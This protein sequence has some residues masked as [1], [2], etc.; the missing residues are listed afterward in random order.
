M[1][2]HGDENMTGSVCIP[3]DSVRRPARGPSANVQSGFSLL[4]VLASLVIMGII[5]ASV[6]VSLR[7]GQTALNTGAARWSSVRS[8]ERLLQSLRK[9]CNA[10]GLGC[11]VSIA[12][13]SLVASDGT[14]IRYAFRKG[15]VERRS[16]NDRPRTINI[17]GLESAGLRLIPSYRSDRQVLVCSLRYDA[18]IREREK[19]YWFLLRTSRP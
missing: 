8:E 9:D 13:L 18:K 19:E 3:A 4:E 10:S 1:S 14:R 11:S 2:E 6:L 16:G 5:T 7:I 15:S 17:P 12:G